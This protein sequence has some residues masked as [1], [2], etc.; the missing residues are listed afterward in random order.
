[1]F[2]FV[3]TVIF[4]S[5]SDLYLI[6]IIFGLFVDYSFPYSH[7]NTNYHPSRSKDQPEGRSSRLRWT[8]LRSETFICSLKTGP[9]CYYFQQR[10]SLC[11][12]V[13]S[14][15]LHL[16]ASWALRCSSCCSLIYPST[17]LSVRAQFSSFDWCQHIISVVLFWVQILS[18]KSLCPF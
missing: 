1:M 10:S 9:I 14:D 13:T 18:A 16:A 15:L 12:L 2:K 8:C 11:S 17:I 5:Y 6:L 4:I 7:L 3:F